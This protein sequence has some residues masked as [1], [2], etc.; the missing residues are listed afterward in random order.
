MLRVCTE[1]FY[2][3]IHSWVLAFGEKH[4]KKAIA[5][6]LEEAGEAVTGHSQFGLCSFFL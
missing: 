5:L 6:C 2:E 3:M 1:L 4:T